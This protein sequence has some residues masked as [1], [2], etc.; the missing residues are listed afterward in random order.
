M[1][2]QLLVTLAIGLLLVLIAFAPLRI[3][4]FALLSL[5]FFDASG[6]D[7]ASATSLGLANA[8]KVLGAPILLILRLKAKPVIFLWTWRKRIRSFWLVL[9]LTLYSLLAILWTPDFLKLGA[10]KGGAYLLSYLLWFALI[11]YGASSRFIDKK[12]LMS[13]FV[14]G[15]LVGL[16]HTYVLDGPFGRALYESSRRFT[17]FSSPQ[18]YAALFSY[19]LIVVLF[20]P[21]TRLISLTLLAALV[22]SVIILT[23]S[24]YSFLMAL[25]GIL[26]WA[27]HFLHQAR[28]LSRLASRFVSIFVLL[29]FFSTGFWV[30]SPLVLQTRMGE[31]F[32]KSVSDVGTFAW[33][34]GMWQEAI[35]QWREFSPLELFF[36]RGTASSVL[37]ALA[38]DSRYDPQTIDANRVM[39]NEFL[40]ALY[41]WGIIGFLALLSVWLSWLVTAL[42]W[43]YK[44]RTPGYLLL[45]TMFPLTGGLLV[46]NILAGSGSPVG[47]GLALALSWV[48]VMYHRGRVDG[49]AYAHPPDSHP[50]PATRR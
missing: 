47:I 30:A 37:V 26:V 8:L 25:S 22:L 49:A 33:R 42:Y 1:E 35:A 28:S 31:L 24:R 45:A 4:Y 9:W 5:A 39:H 36:G 17:A 32:S 21:R 29:V 19:L 38:Y 2:A 46:E 27:F 44:R 11:A 40:K 23:G 16:V 18:S 20:L 34:V 43:V 15:I 14:F 6:P 12:T 48:W 41:E 3:A 13:V 50:L 7:F 10:V